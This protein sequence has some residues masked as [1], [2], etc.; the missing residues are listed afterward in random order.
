MQKIIFLSLFFVDCV[1]T[2]KLD[3]K[4]Y[5]I[6]LFEPIKNDEYFFQNKEVK[7]VFKT[8]RNLSDS[9][10]KAQD[11]LK[12]SFLEKYGIDLVGLSNL[13]IESTYIADSSIFLSD[14][15]CETLSGNPITKSKLKV[16]EAETWR[17]EKNLLWHSH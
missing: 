7:I 14:E 4:S 10:E 17:T 11:F 6:K 8:C 12:Q 16:N 15:V 13:T 2:W 3:P 5:S 1:S 9:G